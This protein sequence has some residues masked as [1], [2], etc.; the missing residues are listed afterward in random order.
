MFLPCNASP[1]GGSASSGLH[2]QRGAAPLDSPLKGL[3]PLRIPFGD[4]RGRAY[5]RGSRRATGAPRRGGRSQKP[6]LCKGRWHGVS[7]DGGIGAACTTPFAEVQNCYRQSLS[8]FGA[9]PF[10]QGSLICSPSRPHSQFRIPNSEF[11]ITEKT[12]RPFSREAF[13]F[14]LT[15]SVHRAHSD[16]RSRWPSGGWCPRPSCRWSYCW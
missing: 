6:P 4:S 16:M 3:R 11:R 13:S 1:R 7:R 5:K 10:T 9:A 12:S 2:R 15:S 8:P 14:V